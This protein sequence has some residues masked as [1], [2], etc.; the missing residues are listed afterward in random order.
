M[1]DIQVTELKDNQRPQ[2]KV[3]CFNLLIYFYLFF[4]QYE[5]H[6]SALIFYHCVTYYNS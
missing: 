6:A 3:N 4:Q 5:N 2:F 1:T